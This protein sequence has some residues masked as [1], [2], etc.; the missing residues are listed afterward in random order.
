[1]LVFKVLLKGFL[2]GDEASMLGAFLFVG[3]NL[4]KLAKFA[5]KIENVSI[6]LV[7]FFKLR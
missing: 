6:E 1:M 5:K 2:E 3:R 4:K 7:F